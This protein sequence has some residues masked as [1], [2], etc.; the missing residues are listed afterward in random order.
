MWSVV[1][2]QCYMYKTLHLIVIATKVGMCIHLYVGQRLNSTMG[3]VLALCTSNL[4][5]WVG[6]RHCINIPRVPLGVIP[7]HKI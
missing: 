4:V 2:Q 6:A 1:E 5:S 7:E 3:R